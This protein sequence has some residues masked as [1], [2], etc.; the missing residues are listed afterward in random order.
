ME[1]E[2]VQVSNDCKL[3]NKMRSLV[4]SDLRLVIYVSGSSPV[5]SYVQRL[6]LCNSRLA[7]IVKQVEVVERN[8][9]WL[10]PSAA[11]L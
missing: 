7:N 8:R 6:A 3:R 5:T 10:L 4:T 11:V 2:K 1:K 9:N